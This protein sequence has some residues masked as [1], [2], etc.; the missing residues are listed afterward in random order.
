VLLSLVFFSK[1]KE[2]EKEKEKKEMKMD[3]VGLVEPK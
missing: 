3:E 1:E 2:K